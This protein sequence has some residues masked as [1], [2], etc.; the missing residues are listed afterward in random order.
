VASKKLWL[1]LAIACTIFILTLSF[2]NVDSFPEIGSNYD[3]KIFH[4]LAYSLLSV[5]WL[6]T[7]EK[8]KKLSIIKVGALVFI[9]GMI[10][11]VFQG[12]FAAHREFDIHDQFANAIGIAISAPLF[13]LWK[14][15]SVKKLL[16]LAF[17]ANYWLFYHS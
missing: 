14:W 17:L 6:I 11:E 2:I 3:D 15:L 12:V 5:L 7:S 4:A 8:W 9:Y 16:T 1:Y 13:L 10:I